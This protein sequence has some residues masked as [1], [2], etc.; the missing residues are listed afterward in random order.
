MKASLLPSG[1]YRVVVSAGYDENGKRKYK[2]FTADEEWKA[3]KMAKEFKDNG[4]EIRNKHNITIRDAMREYIAS[5]ENVIEPTTLTSYN[6]IARCRFQ[7]LLDKQVA[8]IQT[9]DLQRAINV[10]S[11][12]VSAKS[13]KN[14][15][16]LLKS[17]L[18]MY[19]ANINF[20]SIKIPKKQKQPQK[21]L[22]T[23]DVVYSIV[24]GTESELPVLLA[25]WLSLRIGEVIGLQFK[26][27]DTVNNTIQIRRT[28]IYTDKGSQVRDRCK[29][30][31]STRVLQLPSYILN[32]ISEQVH[33]SEDDF[34]IPK[35]RRAV[36][37]QFTR[38][39]AKNG[40]KMTFHDLR[41][42]N[43]S[44]MLMLNIPDKYA[45]ERGGWST[46]SVLKSVYQQTFSSER[47]K[48]DGVID[49]YFNK[50]I[51]QAK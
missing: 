16:A 11:R 12:D 42:L 17:V 21:E 49:E 46:D 18:I 9:I 31:K 10:E 6:Y 41:H 30:D 40:I 35:S 19:G 34:I 15:Y 3:L 39:M 23:F 50:I 47:L 45:M 1:S 24:K 5:R 27:V 36:Y 48:V 8:N 13:V 26:D 25:A 2:S 44:I 28:I 38:L 4:G 20:D 22:P 14:A 29:T 33:S 51:N 43:A 7:Q 32:L 37:G